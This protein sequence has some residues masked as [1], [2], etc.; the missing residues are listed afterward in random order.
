MAVI[1]FVI[2]ASN[3]LHNEPRGSWKV[4]KEKT[5]IKYLRRGD[6]DSE[7]LASMQQRIEAMIAA[8]PFW[9]YGYDDI[10]A[11]MFAPA[12]RFCDLI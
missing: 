4:T 9:G 8:A 11:G 1:Y 12:K 6:L 3:R 7:R 5:I 2:A 10:Y